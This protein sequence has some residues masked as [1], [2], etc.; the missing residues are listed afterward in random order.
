M[1]SL[2][3]CG[4]SSTKTETVTKAAAAV[5]A[6][7]TATAN[8][9]TNF[10]DVIHRVSPQVVQI[11]TPKG[12][13][14][15]VV[16]DGKGDI[17]TNAH[18]VADGGPYTVTDSRGRSY[19][20]TLVGSFTADD[21]AVVRA[22]GLSLP[23]A[24]FANSRDVQ[25]GDV[26]LAIGNPLGLRSSVTDGIIS[27]LGRT[28]NE[29]DGAV[30]PNVIQTSAAINPGNS[31]GALVNLQGDVVGVPTLAATDPE[32]GGAAAG[33][34]FA[35]PSSLVSD[36]AGQIVAHGHVVDS[37]R[38]FLGVTL[39][40]GLVSGAVVV[41]VQPGGPAARAGITPGDVIAS[42][43]GQGISSPTDVAEVLATLRPGQTVTVG[44]LKP[45]GASA[46]VRVTLGQYPGSGS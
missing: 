29:P 14:S 37:H 31:G 39:A 16:M 28:V 6:P 12:L 15:G 2:A 1:L 42:I 13:G 23:A 45:T 5:A 41:S 8:L 7:S 18:V 25:V 46:T 27:A 35:I 11:S 36:I 17:V 34:G 19:P 44:V 26:V 21:V 30:L 32:L 4:G 43:D 22:Q 33:I 24:T 9:Q 40:T 3:A 10:V 38:A 20:G